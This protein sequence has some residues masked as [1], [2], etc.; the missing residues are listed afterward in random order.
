VEIVSSTA[1]E[2]KVWCSQTNQ[3]ISKLSGLDHPEC[4][5]TL[6]T[7]FQWQGADSTGK[8]L[9]L[10][11]EANKANTLKLLLPANT[12]TASAYITLKLKAHLLGNSQVKSEAQ[13]EF[14]AELQDLVA[15]IKGGGMDA[16]EQSTIL[17]DG[18]VSLDPDEDAT[19]MSYRWRCSRDDGLD[20]RDA[21]GTLLS[22]RL[23]GS[24]LEYQLQGAPE[25]NPYIV[26]YTFELTVSKGYR[27]AST[28][29]TITLHPTVE[30]QPLPPLVTILPVPPRVN[31]DQKLQLACSVETTELDKPVVKRWSV[32]P[33]SASTRSLDLASAAATS[34]TSGVLVVKAGSLMGGGSYRFSVTASQSHGN[35]TAYV[36][37]RVN[38][39]SKDGTMRVTPTAATM[40][41]TSVT[42]SGHGWVDTDMPLWYQVKYR[43]VGKSGKPAA[44]SAFT[45][46]SSWTGF[47]P[48]AGLA[49]WSNLVTVYLLVRD[50]LGAGEL[51]HCFM[52][53]DIF[54]RIL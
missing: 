14:L 27:S 2:G 42:I 45:P 39:A 54:P 32:A 11:N 51:L 33:N 48:E 17:L 41:V 50:A 23:T 38:V 16:T 6:G 52:H 28:S 12:L 19:S 37:I 3:V 20:C 47:I 35:A 44:L 53:Y 24:S 40:M 31:Q 21:S 4:V 49:E 1:V 5:N 10:M 36:D 22:S 18:S 8:V 15:L 25:G 9:E 29:T 7:R 26:Q 34:L 43:V 13:T 30:D 46:S